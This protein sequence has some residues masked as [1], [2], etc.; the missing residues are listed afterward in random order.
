MPIDNPE[1][2]RQ[3]AARA[4]DAGQ[5]ANL[6]PT[7]GP[8]DA[9]LMVGIERGH[10]DA[11]AGAHLRHGPSVY[12]LA[13]RMCDAEDADD[14]T[15]EVFLALWRAPERYDPERASLRAH[16]LTQTYREARRRLSTGPSRGP[17]GRSGPGDRQPGRPRLSGEEAWRLLARLPEE[18]RRAIVSAYFGEHT[19]QQVADLLSE[20]DGPVRTHLH[21]CMTELR[22][23]LAVGAFLDKMHLE[24]EIMPTPE[25]TTT[26]ELTSNLAEVARVLFAAGSVADTLQAVVDQAVASIEGCDF[27]GIFLLEADAVATAVKTHPVVLDIDDLQQATGEGPCLDAIEQRTTIYAEDLADDTRWPT[28][29]PQ[30][31]AAGARCALAFHLYTDGTL[32]ALNLYA[33]YPRAFGATDRAKGLIFATLSALALGGARTHEDEDRR[34]INLNQA[35]ATRELIGQ[36]QGILMERERITSDQAF[37]ILRRASQHLNVRL[38]EVAQDLVDTGDRPVTRPPTPGTN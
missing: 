24:P 8:S 29:G 31:A 10:E 7:A 36:A 15:H 26:S 27:A 4:G 32:G 22:A 12:E 16:L 38:R 6:E 19:Y 5:P 21:A 33:Q 13:R 37:D 1:A 2:N 30:A 25:N 23:R 20:Q 35:L 28:F 18:K 34:A 9:A 3:P 17:G 14:V 11:L